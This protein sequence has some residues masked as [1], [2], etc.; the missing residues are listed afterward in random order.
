MKEIE[1]KTINCRGEVQLCWWLPKPFYENIIEK[2]KMLNKERKKKG[3]LHLH[4]KVFIFE[5]LQKG[6]SNE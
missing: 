5:I 3:Q 6:F 4:F 2:F 1:K